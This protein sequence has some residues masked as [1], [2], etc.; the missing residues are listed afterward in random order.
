M[1]LFLVYEREILGELIL[2][3]L[4]KLT[5]PESLASYFGNILVPNGILQSGP[6]NI[7]LL[8]LV[9]QVWPRSVSC[10]KNVKIEL[11]NRAP[12]K[13]GVGVTKPCPLQ[14]QDQNIS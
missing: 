12:L 6:Q 2:I 4:T 14:K 13:G 3:N 7:Y 11:Q 5:L 9:F 10:E 1:G 8:N